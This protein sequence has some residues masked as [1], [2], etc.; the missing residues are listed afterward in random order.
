MKEAAAPPRVPVCSSELHGIEHDAV[1][2]DYNKG[3]PVCGGGIRES[4]PNRGFPALK[5][6]VVLLPSALPPQSRPAV[7][8][9]STTKT[10]LS[11]DAEFSTELH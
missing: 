5:E 11:L 1:Q 6:L 10:L 2:H 4:W 7:T 3:A 8:A 9:Q